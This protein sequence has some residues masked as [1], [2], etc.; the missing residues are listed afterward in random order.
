M[1]PASPLALGEREACLEMIRYWLDNVA[2]HTGT[3]SEVQNAALVL[4]GTHK[5][6]VSS[7]RDHEAISQLLWSRFSQ[8][9]QWPFVVPLK[10]GVVSTGRG[11]LWFYP[12][13]NTRAS[14]VGRDP[15]LGQLITS[16]EGKVQAQD[17]VHRL[18]PFTWMSL[19]DKLQEELHAGKLVVSMHTVQGLARDCGVAVEDV[20]LVLRYFDCMGLLLYCADGRMHGI[21][22]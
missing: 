12:V 21:H 5:D 18:V 1:P 4:V 20:E 8:H 13:D 16:L 11:L 3:G 22:V 6:R 7:A 9:V 2:L 17:H 10:E 19:Y 15:V 14:G